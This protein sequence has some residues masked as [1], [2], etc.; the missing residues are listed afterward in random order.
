MHQEIVMFAIAVTILWVYTVMSDQPEPN[1]TMTHN[2]V[3]SNT[4]TH[5]QVHIFS[6]INQNPGM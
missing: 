6:I 5:I 1:T 4:A 2:H 3:K